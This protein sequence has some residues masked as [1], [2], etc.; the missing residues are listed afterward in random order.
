M[1]WFQSLFLMTGGTPASRNWFID[2]TQ[3]TSLKM[4]PALLQEQF[5]L[6]VCLSAYLLVY[7]SSCLTNLRETNKLLTAACLINAACLSTL[8]Q[9]FTLHVYLPMYSM[10]AAY[11]QLHPVDSP[12]IGFSKC[13]CLLVLLW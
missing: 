1:G 4:Q 9:T 12:L 10:S 11:E 6:Y 5:Y 13:V 2:S 3:A 8:E 7:L